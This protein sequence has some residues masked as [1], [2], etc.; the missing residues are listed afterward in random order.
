MASISD[1]SDLFLAAGND[2]HDEVRQIFTR[3]VDLGMRFKATERVLLDGI[4][5]ILSQVSF[6]PMPDIG[7]SYEELFRLFESIAAKS[8]NWASPNFLG[9]PD[10][11]NNVAGV[12]AALLTEPKYGKPRDLLS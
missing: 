10:A 6:S 8:S 12:A 3:V 9:F 11:G 2:N 1:L 7:V 5:T 4:R